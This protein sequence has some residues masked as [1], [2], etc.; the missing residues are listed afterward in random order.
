MTGEWKNLAQIMRS[1][2]VQ[3]NKGKQENDYERQIR[4]REKAFLYDNFP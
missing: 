3:Q 1:N 4:T 2:Q